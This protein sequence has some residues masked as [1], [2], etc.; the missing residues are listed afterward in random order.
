MWQRLQTLL[1]LLCIAAALVFLFLP[2]AE[3]EEDI[4]YAKN[5]IFSTAIS[6]AI[7]LLSAF[8]IFLYKDRRLQMRIC[9]INI[10]FSVALLVA[11]IIAATTFSEYIHFEFTAGIPV[12]ILIGQY[13]AYRRIKK[14]EDLVRSMDRF[15]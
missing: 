9:V 10:F 11:A 15:R 7:I 14:D 6:V 12:L 3:L 1:L 5:D 4:L 13:L 8:T 2:L